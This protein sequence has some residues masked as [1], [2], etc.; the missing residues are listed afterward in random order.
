MSQVYNFTVGQ[1]E[2]WDLNINM[3]DDSDNLLDLTGYSYSGQIRDAYDSSVVIAVFTFEIANQFTDRG[4]VTLSLTHDQT[5]NI[6]LPASSGNQKKPSKE[7]LYDI[8]ETD[9]FGKV[10][11]I[12]E[13]SV[14]VTAGVTK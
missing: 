5:Q 4:R 11:R 12:L 9:T 7:Y 6:P 13:G 14:I 10:R 1:G 2:D 3:K 8:K